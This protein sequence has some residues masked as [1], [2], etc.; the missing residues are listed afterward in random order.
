MFNLL[1]YQIQFY[2]SIWLNHI[3]LIYL[4]VNFKVKCFFVG[5]IFEHYIF[6]VLYYTANASEN[7]SVF[8]RIMSCR[9]SSRFFCWKNVLHFRI[10]FRNLFFKLFEILSLEV[11][12]EYSFGPSAVSNHNHVCVFA[13]AK[14]CRFSFSREQTPSKKSFP[15]NVRAPE[16]RVVC[17]SACVLQHVCFFPMC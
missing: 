8:N 5:V 4:S 3:V 1:I 11:F 12:V 14:L 13:G 9:R 6:K 15:P 10:L 2:D 17:V 16:T 7:V